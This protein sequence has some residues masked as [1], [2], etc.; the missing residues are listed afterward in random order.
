MQSWLA[1][2]SARGT[3]K[4]AQASARDMTSTRSVV[5][6]HFCSSFS[7][8]PAATDNYCHSGA[9]ACNSVPPRRPVSVFFAANRHRETVARALTTPSGQGGG[10]SGGGGGGGGRGGGGG[11][12]TP[13]EKLDRWS[14]GGGG[15]LSS[16]K[17][18]GKWKEAPPVGARAVTASQLPNPPQGG[19][20]GPGT[21]TKQLDHWP[22]G[23]GGLLSPSKQDGMWKETPPGEKKAVTPTHLPT[24][25]PTH[26][27]SS[28]STADYAAP[29]PP[30]AVKEDKATESMEGAKST[31]P[32]A[33]ARSEPR[34]CTV[35]VKSGSES[36]LT[37][38]RSK[39]VWVAQQRRATDTKTFQVKVVRGGRLVGQ[40]PPGFSL[41]PAPKPRKGALA[42]FSMTR[43]ATNSIIWGLIGSL[44]VLVLTTMRMFSNVSFRLWSVFPTVNAS[45][46]PSSPALPS[47]RRPTVGPVTTPLTLSNA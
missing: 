14:T 25:L 45:P 7:S 39:G 3:L 12:S 26:P 8:L 28:T 34:P 21:P 36:F 23:G 4:R 18:D 15:F 42:K 6:P 16:S 40:R 20:G 24:P 46:V 11:P 33:A 47:P 43:A 1:R 9:P 5:F 37:H 44:A 41:H 31:T 22:T 27:V 35:G 2:A 38:S 10:S 29:P 17:K 19:G 32:I 30:R 13:V